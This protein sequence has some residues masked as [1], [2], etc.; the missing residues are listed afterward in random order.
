M[1]KSASLLDIVCLFSL[2]DKRVVVFT[3]GSVLCQSDFL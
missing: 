2:P 3:Q 1:V